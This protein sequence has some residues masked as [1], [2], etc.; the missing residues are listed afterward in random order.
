MET[1]RS[2]KGFLYKNFNTRRKVLISDI[3][4]SCMFKF[5]KRK[6]PVV[7]VKGT[8]VHFDTP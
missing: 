5:I 1:A 8:Q 3:P 6:E 4:V 2:C 7:Q